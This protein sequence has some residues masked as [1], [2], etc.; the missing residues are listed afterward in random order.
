VRSALPLLLSVPFLA[1]C[2]PPAALTCESDEAV[3][4]RAGGRD[5]LVWEP[6]D[7]ELTPVATAALFHGLGESACTWADRVEGRRFSERLSDLGFV[8][9]AL[10]S[11]PNKSHWGTSWPINEDVTAVD[12]SLEVLIRDGVVHPSVPAV[13][14]GH[15]NGGTFAPIWAEASAALSVVAAVDAN[16]WGSEALSKQSDVPSLLFITAENDMIVPNS[17]TEQATKRAQDSGHDVQTIQNDRQSIAWNRF[18]RIPGIDEFESRSIFDTL[19]SEGL[20]DSEQKLS[21]NPRLDRRWETALPDELA[22][23]A[24]SIEEQLHVLYAEHRFSSDNSERIIR[25][26]EG[27]LD[28]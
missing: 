20:L 7:P 10:D 14:L 21:V 15:S 13:A 24:S 11:G 19:S 3:V 8:V 12:A 27:A 6:T 1:A 22:E 5:V 2:P 9:V 16:G 25:F 23:S 18:A 4:L 17:L 26:F 28:R